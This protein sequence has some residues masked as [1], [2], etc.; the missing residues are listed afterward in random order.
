MTNWMFYISAGNPTEDLG[1]KE[2]SARPRKKPASLGPIPGNV[3]RSLPR[4]LRYGYSDALQYLHPTK[5]SFTR[6]LGYLGGHCHVAPAPSS[7]KQKEKFGGKHEAPLS[8][9]SPPFPRNLWN[10]PLLSSCLLVKGPTRLS[11]PLRWRRS[12]RKRGKNMASQ[13]DSNP[14]PE[15]DRRRGQKERKREM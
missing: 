8:H 7:Q 14:R 12:L 4:R 5:V 11:L 1:R 15:G 9:P 3:S 13:T 2:S 10:P 6:L